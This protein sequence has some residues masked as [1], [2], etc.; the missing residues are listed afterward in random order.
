MRIHF[1]PALA[2]LR[3]IRA[4]VFPDLAQKGEYLGAD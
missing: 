3:R 1:R 4:A 2:F